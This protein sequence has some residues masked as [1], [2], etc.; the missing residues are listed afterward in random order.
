[1][2]TQFYRTHRFSKLLIIYAIFLISTSISP[3]TVFAQGYTEGGAGS[4]GETVLS[5]KK[6]QYIR[7]VYTSGLAHFDQIK[8]LAQIVG[9]TSARC[10]AESKENEKS[11]EDALATCN[12][13]TSENFY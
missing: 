5:S 6:I 1:M 13:V 8:R 11:L 4:G 2:K 3:L 10:L 9:S 12:I 7:L